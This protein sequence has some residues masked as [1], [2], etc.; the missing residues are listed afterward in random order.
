[1]SVLDSP[2]QRH[3]QLSFIG[4]AIT[5]LAKLREA[6]DHVLLLSEI[7]IARIVTEI[8]LQLLPN[9]E[10]KPIIDYLLARRQRLKTVFTAGR[11]VMSN[12]EQ[13]AI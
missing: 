11:Q 7:V 2:V 9:G 10:Q 12:L 4:D 5:E 8:P 6:I 3:I 1:M 13:G